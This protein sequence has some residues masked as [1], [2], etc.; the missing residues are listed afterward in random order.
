MDEFEVELDPSL[1]ED[2]DIL[3]CECGGN[4]DCSDLEDEEE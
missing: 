4:C 2:E 3:E 1:F